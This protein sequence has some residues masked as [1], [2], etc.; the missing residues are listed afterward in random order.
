MALSIHPSV[1]VARLGNS[2]TSA[3]VSPI[4]AVTPT[5]PSKICLSPDTIGGLPFDGYGKAPIVNFKDEAGRIKK[6]GQLFKVFQENGKDELTLDTPGVASIEWTVHLANKKA[7]WYQ[8]QELQGNLLYGQQNSYKNQQVPFRNPELVSEKDRQTLI[9]DPGPRTISGRSA[10]IDFDKANVPAGYPAQYPSEQVNY[11]LAVKTLGSLWTDESGRLIV[12]GGSGCAG[13]N[14]PLT[15]YGGSSTWHDDISDGPVYCT[16]TFNDGKP[17]VK[18]SAWVI[19]GSPDFAPEIVN[20]ATLSDTMFDVGV[21]NFNLV[22]EMCNKGVWNQAFKASYQRDIYPIIDRMG[23]YQWVSNVQPMQAAVN[24]PFDYSDPSD[25]NKT[26]RANFYALFRQNDT[27]PP[28]E[29]NKKGVQYPQEALFTSEETGKMFPMMPLNS[30]SNSVS[31][32]NIMKFMALN[33]TQLFLLKQWAD[34]KFDNNPQYT[35]YPVHPLDAASVGNC[36]GLPMC[37]GIEVT[38]SM[39]NP[40]VYAAP[41]IIKQYKDEAWY[42]TNGLTPSRDEC[43][44]GGCEPGDLTKRMACPWQADFFQCTIQYVN[45]TNPYANK[46]T[47]PDGTKM[48][49]PPNYY[50]YWWPPQS[51]WDVLVGEFTAEGQAA[52][53]VPAG[54]QMNYARGINS[55]VQMVEYWYALGFL[56]DKNAGAE[57]GYPYIVET[58]RNNELFTYK[59]IHIGQISGNIQDWDTTL[60]VFYIE[61]DKAKVKQR[62]VMAAAMVSHMEEAAFKV[63]ETLSTTSAHPRSGTKSRR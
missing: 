29:G 48:P 21:R 24:A 18:L 20:I 35:P 10:A 46:T 55:F 42:K 5:D 54:E 32:I 60:P 36:V 43:E 47:L 23:R 61:P 52:T 9:V 33:E 40:D 12:L 50:T 39:Q 63:I 2:P 1:G 57:N 6:Q 15:S 45:F 11:G 14:L 27:Q 49:L 28:V 16:V 44:G 13:G 26:N 31:N 58:E 19:V 4:I 51:P 8:Y 25:Q 34:G 7:A 59:E 17:Q 30:G 38:W 37:P 56:R 3:S 62:S 53:H 41:Y 22:P